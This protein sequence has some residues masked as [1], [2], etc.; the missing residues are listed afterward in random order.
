MAKGEANKEN[1][2]FAIEH[3]LLSDSAIC[4]GCYQDGP[5]FM[6]ITCKRNAIRDALELIKKQ[7]QWI[8]V[9]DRMP[10]ELHSI[11]F[12]LYGTPKWKSAMWREESDHV[13]VTVVFDDGTRYVSMGRTHDGEWNTNISKAV[14]HTVT[15]WMPLPEPPKEEK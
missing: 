10:P 1:I 4:E 7:P 14:H 13:L 9:E 8:S 2:I 5:G 3:C 11:W 6:G 12:L 15:H